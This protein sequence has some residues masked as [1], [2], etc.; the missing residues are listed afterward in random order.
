MNFLIAIAMLANLAYLAAAAAMSK[1]KQTSDGLEKR[2]E[3]TFAWK[4]YAVQ[5]CSA[6]EL[7]RNPPE[8]SVLAEDC[9]WVLNMITSN[10][11]GYF[12][13]WDFETHVFKP[14]IGYQS[15]VLAVYHSVNQNASDYAM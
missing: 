4:Q 8:K 9:Q 11:G 1:Y 10:N 3:V 15:C 5:N 12:E 13:L 2:T 14:I 6:L 7:E